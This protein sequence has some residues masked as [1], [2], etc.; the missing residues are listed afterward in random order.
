[1]SDI[2]D[3]L[4]EKYSEE[5]GL[6]F[7]LFEVLSFLIYLMAVYTVMSASDSGVWGSILYKSVGDLLLSDGAVMAKVRVVDFLC[8][9]AL[10]L[11]TTAA[12][13]KISGIV[14]RYLAT[15][16]N[17]EDY[18]ERIKGRYHVDAMG[19]AA[20]R[21]YIANVANEQK[22]EHMKRITLANGVGLISL[23]LVISSVLGLA[24]PNVADFAIFGSGILLLCLM[25]WA[26]FTKYTAQVIPRLVLE[27]LARNENVEFG[28][29]LE[30]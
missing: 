24:N 16:K 3:A 26:V 12:Y 19:G 22:H 28:D 29:E 23:V 4:K 20:M 17:M 27:R 1:M 6:S 7:T 11:L 10:T 15:L 25:Q 21:I 18:V 13:R 30:Q 14:Y 5:I 9:G 2:L 8:A